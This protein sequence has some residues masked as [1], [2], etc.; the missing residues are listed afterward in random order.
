MKYTLSFHTASVVGIGISNRPLIDFLLDHGVAVTARDR[1]EREALE[2]F[3]TALEAKGVRLICG[4]NYLADITDEAVFRAPGV[5]YDKPELVEAVQHGARLTSE[6]ELFFD[7]TPATIIGVT[8]SNG[9]TTTTTLIAK[10]LSEKHNVYVG[11]NIGRPLIGDVEK[12]TA[13]DIA[14]VELSSF[15]LHT[16]KKS[17]HISVVTNLY[18]NHLDYHTDM[19]EYV[20]AKKNIFLHAPCRRLITNFTCARTK[21]LEKDVRPETQ[22]VY[23]NTNGESGIGVRGGIIT[24]D[25]E[26]VLPVS[27]IRLPGQCNVE[28][29]MAAIGAVWGMCD[30]ETIRN[31]ARTFGGVEHRCELVCTKNGV[32]YF[33]SS[34]DSSPSRTIATLGCF[35]NS[36]PV[37]LILGG[38]DKQIP[39]DD[40]A[41]PV[42]AQARCVIL[43]GATAEKIGAV[44]RSA[45]YPEENL[46]HIPDFDQAIQA[47]S[48][49]AIPGDVV[50][51]SPA[52][53]SFDAFPN[54]EVRGRKFK[55]L[56]TDTT[57]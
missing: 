38:Y 57:E 12:M 48:S 34:I 56:I 20:D 9:K 31:L 11:G 22:L 15:Q 55:E 29:Y 35:P 30:T 40:L 21:E 49:H 43:T 13:D 27:E 53:A 7:L 25:G 8:G 23:F 46:H 36:Q 41:E 16:M 3:A 4:E 2:P 32:R 45:G 19:D 54:F 17:P 42:C 10:M 24:M 1:K 6:M 5:R 51:F 50:L 47:A 18:P 52:C 44:L 39:F 14:V 33:N 26:P 28:N 37:V